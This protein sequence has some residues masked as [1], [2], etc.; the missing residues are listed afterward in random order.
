MTPR[1][2]KSFLLV[3]IAIVWI[4]AA[5]TVGIMVAGDQPFSPLLPISYWWQHQHTPPLHLIL[6]TVAAVIPATALL[7][8]N[9]WAIPNEYGSAH[10]ASNR[11]IRKMGLRANTG[12]LLGRTGRRFLRTDQPLS[13]LLL[14]PPGTGKTAGVVVPTLL[15]CGNSM[16]VNDVK[17]ELYQLTS[18]RRAEFSK[19]VKFAPGQKDSCRWNPLGKE[20]L[21][22]DW[23]DIVVHVERI[24]SVLF[25]GDEESKTKVDYWPLEAASAFIFYALYLIHKNGETSIPEVRSFALAADDPQAAIAAILD[26]DDGLPARVTEEGNGLVAKADREFSGVFGTFKSKLNAF[27]DPY[28][29]RA[30]SGNDFAF[31]DFRRE[32]TTLY[33]TIKPEDIQRLAPLL[34]LLFEQAALYILS[35]APKPD[36]YTITLVLDE[37]VRLG[38]LKE[39]LN[40]PALSRGNRGNAILIAQNH[41]QISELYGPNGPAT[42]E[43]T[44]GY[45][46]VLAQNDKNTAKAISEKIGNYTRKRTTRSTGGS[47]PFASTSTSFEGVPLV[48]PQDVMDMPQWHAIVLVQNH[49]AKPIKAKVIPWF[50]DRRLRKLVGCIEPTAAASSTDVVS[51][52]AAAIAADAVNTD[53]AAGLADVNTTPDDQLAAPTA[54][55]TA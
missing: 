50:K 38:R 36:D 7:V 26:E 13:V 53:L 42:L 23:N 39:V 15:S 52:Q 46:I 55:R 49:N 22:S 1:Q 18:K 35:T 24:A 41:A 54:E 20:A 10:W 47:G 34:R 37:F 40:M 45:Q 30:M 9:P 33:L 32:R 12:L 14:A 2:I 19:V 25:L 4:Y 29:Q 48:L 17:G 43:G 28:V 3:I 44:C 16:I 31:A 6:V 5:L 51:G 21:P 8:W 11:E 27:A